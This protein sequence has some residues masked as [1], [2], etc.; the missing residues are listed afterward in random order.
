MDIPSRPTGSMRFVDS[1]TIDGSVRVGRYELLMQLASGG[2]ATVYIGRQR[3]AG[4]FE[5]IVAIKRMHPHIGAIPELAESFMDEARIASLIH[6]PNVVSVHDVHE[7]EDGERLLVMDYVE[8]GSLANMVR[9]AKKR[10]IK[11][12]RPVALRII[13]EALRGLHAAHE[14]RSMTGVPLNIVHRDATPQNI[15]IGIDGAVKITDFGIARAAER[16]TQTVAGQ[17][18]GKFRYMAPEQARGK[19]VDRRVDIFAMGVVLFELLADVPF[20]KGDSDVEIL[21]TL[22]LG[23]FTPLHEVDPT[24]PQDLSAIVMQAV[25]EAPDDRWATAD[26]FASALDAWA[27]QHAKT[28]TATEVA[29]MLNELCG[30]AIEERRTA[31][32]EVLSGQRA[33]AEAVFS[34]SYTTANG[35][36]GQGSGGSYTGALN[37]PAQ[38]I[39]GAPLTPEGM[40]TE[41]LLTP[42]PPSKRKPLLLAGLGVAALLALAGGVLVAT[43]VPQQEGSVSAVTPVEATATT[44]T[45]E[46]R[47]TVTVSA[48]QPVSEV[49]AP[50]IGDIAFNDT[51][52]TFT[53]PKD[54]A[55]VTV[56][57][58]MAD[59]TEREA[60][61][62]PSE[63]AALR[64]V[65][66]AATADEGEK[67]EAP[68]DP[69]PPVV[70]PKSTATAKLP[71][72]PPTMRKNPYD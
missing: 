71:V 42:A 24:V 45:P 15:L 33:P 35:G 63:S 64:L 13:V 58:R 10:G 16:S 54:S 32:L 11:L 39:T 27:R 60:S 6:H 40:F 14:Q 51:S 31:L 30:S 21:R 37:T 23:Q 3:G 55:T 59:G 48:E 47:I 68:K 62:T 67:K 26:E 19:D 43:K 7:G 1:R 46:P 56:H 52:T 4:G 8:G 65:K 18:K 61:V 44:P 41:Q 34:A 50:S 9:G 22:A 12:P 70:T 66:P 17:V 29:R 36:P 20:L 2:M 28:A 38:P 53:L 25:A 72:K 5:K 57:F 49:R 69:P